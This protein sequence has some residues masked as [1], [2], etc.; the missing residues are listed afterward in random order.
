[1][2]SIDIARRVCNTELE[3]LELTRD[4]LDETFDNIVELCKSK[5]VASDIGDSFRIIKQHTGR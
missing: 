4:A 5:Y 1:M 3:A 2:S